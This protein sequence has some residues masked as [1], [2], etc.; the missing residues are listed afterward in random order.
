MQISAHKLADIAADMEN[1]AINGELDNV[2]S[3]I[4][5]LDEEFELL[6]AILNDISD[7][8]EIATFKPL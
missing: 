2:R 6:K 5:G 3:L 4:S 7:N 8:P 1:Y